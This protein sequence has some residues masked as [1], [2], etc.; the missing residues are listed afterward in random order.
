[1]NYFLLGDILWYIGHL[2]SA[3]SILFSRTNYPAAIALTMC[4]QFLTII[5]RPIGRINLTNKN[6]LKENA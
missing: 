2:L 6:A 1:M 4:G 5:S 3:S